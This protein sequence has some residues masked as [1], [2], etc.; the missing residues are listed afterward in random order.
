MGRPK[1]P[2]ISPQTEQGKGTQTLKPNDKNQNQKNPQGNVIVTKELPAHS[3]PTI[4]PAIDAI[5]ET[6]RAHKTTLDVAIT[7]MVPII[8]CKSPE[9][10]PTS[11]PKGVTTSTPK[12]LCLF[13][14]VMRCREMLLLR[15]WRNHLRRM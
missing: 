12:A 8:M 4:Q 15:I 13:L 1:K 14:M 10:M 11:I 6:F 7:P 3:S 9:V 5:N 2:Q